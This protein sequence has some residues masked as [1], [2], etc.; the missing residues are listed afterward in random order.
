MAREP[1]GRMLSRALVVV[2]GHQICRN[3]LD[4]LKLQSSRKV[5]EHPLMT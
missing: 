4:T 5:E 3:L 2:A 1:R